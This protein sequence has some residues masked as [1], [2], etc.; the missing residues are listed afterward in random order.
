MTQQCEESWRKRVVVMEEH[1]YL[2]TVPRRPEAPGEQT[3]PSPLCFSDYLTLV[4][5]I[6]I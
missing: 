2:P 1:G 6:F 5:V 4:S 3:G